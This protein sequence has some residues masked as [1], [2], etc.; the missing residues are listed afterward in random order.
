MITKSLILKVIIIYIFRFCYELQE[1]Q[2][3]LLQESSQLQTA[4]L[5]FSKARDR[6]AL[7]QEK[8]RREEIVLEEK[9][10]VSHSSFELEIIFFF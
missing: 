1:W 2:N 3:M 6:H 4:I 5:T 8:L 10:K 9:G 7:W